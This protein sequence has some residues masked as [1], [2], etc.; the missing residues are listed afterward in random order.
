MPGLL[1]RKLGMTSVYTADGT[2]VPVTVIDV[3]KC[4]VVDIKTKEKDGYNALQIG[5][6]EKKEKHVSKPQLGH[7][8]KNNLTPA[9][10]LKEFKSFDVSEYKIGDSITVDI[11]TEGDKIKVT[12]LTKGKG[13]QGVMKRHGFSGVG[14]RTHGQGD[15]ERAPGSIGSSSYPSRVFKGTKMAGRTGYSKS[16]MSG[17]KVVKIIP[18]KNLILVKGAV[19]GSVNS[20][21]EIKK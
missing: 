9:L 13:F 17:S 8:S 6:G 10:V 19:P 12:G 4:S 2:I 7:Y 16:T 11:F 1:G 18:E 5:F 20:I 3:E 15:R 21:V 14:G